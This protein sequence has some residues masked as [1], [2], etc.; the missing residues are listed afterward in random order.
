MQNRGPKHGRKEYR[1][2][3]FAKEPQIKSAILGSNE[4]NKFYQTLMKTNQIRVFHYSAGV[5]GNF[6]A[7][8]GWNR[9]G[10]AKFPS[11]SAFAT[12][13][14]IPGPVSRCTSRVIFVIDNEKP[15]IPSG[16]NF[17]ATSRRIE[18][19]LGAPDPACHPRRTWTR[20]SRLSTSPSTSRI[21]FR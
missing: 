8:R 15:G 7:W 5:L 19:A 3:K 6:H 10:S 17:Q 16:E 11:R 21:H 1:K 13:T 12:F 4:R 20:F 14:R 18:R 9:D 2:L